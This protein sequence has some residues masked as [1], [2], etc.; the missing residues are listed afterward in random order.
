MPEAITMP[1]VGHVMEEGTVV[2]WK[3]Q[4]GDRIEKGDIVLDIEMDKSVFEVEAFI[5][6]TM[7]EILV[8]EGETVRVGTP[9]AMVG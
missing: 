8:G 3:K 5:S 4:V 9:L 2:T 7:L 6:G 1:K